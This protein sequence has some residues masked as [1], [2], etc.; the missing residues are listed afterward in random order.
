MGFD[1]TALP[2]AYPVTQ[3]QISVRVQGPCSLLEPGPIPNFLKKPSVETR[4]GAYNRI[5]DGLRLEEVVV[6]GDSIHYLPGTQTQQWA[7]V[8]FGVYTCR[9]CMVHILQEMAWYTC[10]CTYLLETGF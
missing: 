6:A 8:F 4:F 10:T 3:R 5:R 2:P 9:D 7:M 1:S